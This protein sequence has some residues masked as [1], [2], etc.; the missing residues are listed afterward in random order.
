L[1]KKNEEEAKEALRK[2]AEFDRALKNAIERALK[3]HRVRLCG[4]YLALSQVEVIDYMA[5]M[6]FT[7]MALELLY[8]TSG[9]TSLT[10]ADVV[11]AIKMVHPGLTVVDKITKWVD[12]EDAFE[13]LAKCTST[14]PK[15]R[16]LR[17]LSLAE[18]GA[19]TIPKLQDHWKKRSAEEEAEGRTDAKKKR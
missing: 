8:S 18:Q 14:K 2:K 13:R 6:R 3:Q 4:E 19:P 5:L 15:D 1:Q 11:N 9:S 7:S 12:V 10:P 17:L 16:L